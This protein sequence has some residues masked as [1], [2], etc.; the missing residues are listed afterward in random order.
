MDVA[1][2]GLCGG[3]VEAVAGTINHAH[4]CPARQDASV[5]V[6]ELSAAE[7]REL[8]ELRAAAPQLPWSIVES[9]DADLNI[10]V[11]LTDAAG[12]FM[13]QD[14]QAV[15]LLVAAVNILPKILKE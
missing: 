3:D 10:S 11:Y 4:T 2:C 5:T 6:G 8:S 7:R 15:R 14:M 1:H 13:P 9:I 12:D